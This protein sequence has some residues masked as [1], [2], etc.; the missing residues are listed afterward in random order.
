MIGQKDSLRFLQERFFILFTVVI[1]GFTIIFAR[2]AY[3]EVF[4]GRKFRFISDR[5]SLKEEVLPGPRGQ[6]LDR[7]GKVLVDNRL[8]LDLQLSR[9]QAKDPEASLAKVAQISGLSLEDLKHEYDKEVRQKQSFAP[10]V[11]VRDLPRDVATKI[12]A[13]KADLE[14]ISVEARIKRL[15]LLKEDGAQLFGYTGMATK[16][17]LDHEKYDGIK[18]QQTD[19]I[20]KFGIEKYLDDKIRGR[21]GARYVVVDVHGRRLKK[22]DEEKVLGDLTQEHA[23]KPGN[24]VQ[25]TIDSDIQEA[26]QLSMKDM[27]GAV[28]AMNVNTGEILALHSQP[29][30]DPTALS[31]NSTA[32]WE[33]VMKNEFAPLRNKVFQDHFSPGSTFKT[34][35]ALAGLNAGI[36]DPEKKVFCSGKYQLGNRTFHCD[37]KNGHGWVNLRQ[38]IQKSCN[39]YFYTVA[40]QMKSV[41]QISD[42]ARHFGFGHSVGL[43]LE[44]ESNGLLPTEDWKEKTLGQRWTQGETLMVAIGQS[45]TLVTPIQLAMAYATLANGGTLYKPY[46]VEEIKSPGGTVLEE[47][48]PTIVDHIALNPQHVAEV[49]GGLDDVVNEPGGTGYLT[50]RSKLVHIAGKSGT[51]SVQQS[52][53]ETD[54]YRSCESFPPKQRP[55][56]WF[57][58]FA[59]EEKPEIVV[60]VISMHGCWGAS[61]GGPVVKS[62]IEKW[63]E[64][65]KLHGQPVSQNQ[66][67]QADLSGSAR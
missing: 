3:L 63:Y 56:G 1:V 43:G 65:Y 16:G 17:D 42:F 21:E 59:P 31:L 27:T 66:K 32:E 4:N 12:E 60:A 47:N 48:K 23:A 19:M 38:A 11:L 24:D 36:I 29:G 18:F 50:V 57:V 34:F 33:K 41:D 10:V 40:E 37:A 61:A 9:Q 30:F 62:V 20:G 45:Y 52:K 46:V 6:I 13:N 54:L 7:N 26:A 35:T 64:K 5:N 55:H 51:V 67:A 8:E 44:R 25:L 22:T 2:I 15:Y 58:G 53:N 14:G 49:M 39:V 28:V